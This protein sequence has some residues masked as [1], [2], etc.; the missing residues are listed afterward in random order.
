MCGISASWPWCVCA[1]SACLSVCLSLCMTQALIQSMS[2]S[3]VRG[4]WSD[5]FQIR[6]NPEEVSL[7]FPLPCMGPTVLQGQPG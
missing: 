5:G 4:I 6:G 7:V 3:T 1:L 2:S